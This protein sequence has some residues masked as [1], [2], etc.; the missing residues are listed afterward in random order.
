MGANSNWSNNIPV[1]AL[2]YLW[3]VSPM[4]LDTHLGRYREYQKCRQGPK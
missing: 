2:L 1:N 3:G 4:T